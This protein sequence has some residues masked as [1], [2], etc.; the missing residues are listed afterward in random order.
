MYMYI[1]VRVEIP[2]GRDLPIVRPPSQKRACAFHLVDGGVVG[3]RL[4]KN[5]GGFD[6]WI[7][8]DGYVD[9]CGLRNPHPNALGYGFR[10]P[11]RSTCQST[12]IHISIR[13]LFQLSGFGVAPWHPL[14]RRALGHFDTDPPQ[15]PPGSTPEPRLPEKF[16]RDRAGG[17]G[18]D[19]KGHIFVLVKVGVPPG[20]R[21]WGRGDESPTGVAK[22]Q[23][24]CRAMRVTQSQPSSTLMH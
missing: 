11:H 4:Q 3:H 17:G 22:S 21:V 18:G 6:M 23:P 2:S 16:I 10:H 9:R 5:K 12:S 24:S 15:L 13:Q 8:V 20:D 1:C 7:D 19:T 14:G